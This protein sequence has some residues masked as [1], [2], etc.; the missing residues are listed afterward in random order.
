MVSLVIA[1][2]H[3]NDTTTENGIHIHRIRR[4]NQ[5]PRNG[6]DAC[7]FFIFKNCGFNN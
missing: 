4:V 3:G 6:T 1:L 2:S 7:L 5:L